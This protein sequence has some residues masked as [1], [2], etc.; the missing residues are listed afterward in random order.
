M[1]HLLRIAAVL[2]ILAFGASAQEEAMPKIRMQ[3]EGSVMGQTVKGAPYSADEVTQSTQVLAD[4]T[5]IHHEN[6]IAVYRDGEGRVRRESSPDQI[7]IIDPVAR[8]SFFLNPKTMT[9]QKA[10]AMVGYSFLHTGGE[11]GP[12]LLGMAPGM[13]SESTFTM[14][15][16]DGAT[17]VNINGTPVEEKVVAEA[18]ARAKQNGESSTVNVPVGEYRVALDKS[19]ADKEKMAAEKA[20]MVGSMDTKV[21]TRRGKSEDLGKQTIEGVIAEGTRTTSTIDVGAIGNDRPIQIVTERWYSAE[22]QTVLMT[23]TSDPR[24][25]EST[26][27][28]TNVHRGEPGAYLFQVPAGYT[29]ADRK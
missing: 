28:L 13:R 15:T 5:R 7:T 12:G 9:A 23:K 2:P 21:M 22:L 16:R 8:T 4:G 1:Q 14:I 6:R 18:I 19:A 29:I 3:L 26:F 25:G 20:M 10:P 27:S 17:S 24:M 11:G